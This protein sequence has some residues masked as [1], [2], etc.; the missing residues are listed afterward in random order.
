MKGWHVCG[1]GRAS[2]GGVGFGG[3][4]AAEHAHGRRS[5]DRRAAA[6][7]GAAAAAGR[8]A[9]VAAGAPGA[10]AGRGDSVPQIAQVFAGG[11]DGVRPWRRRYREPGAAGRADR[12][13][14]GRAPRAPGAAGG[15]RGPPP[16]DRAPVGRRPGRP[17]RPDVVGPSGAPRPARHGLALGAAPPGP[18]DARPHSPAQAG[19][20]RPAD[21][22]ADRASAGRH[23][24]RSLPGRVRSAPAAGGPRQGDEGAA[25]ARADPGPDRHTRQRRRPDRPHRRGPVPRPAQAAGG[26]VRRTARSW[27]CSRRPTPR[28]RSCSSWTT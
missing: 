20:G 13:R 1:Y 28:A 16:R 8:G 14:A 26:P 11:A 5:A 22:A 4:L 21:A 2:A 23:G 10:A 19:P 6:G 27:P 7:V 25:A 15:G 12:P 17:L 24:D 9:G 18:D 3:L